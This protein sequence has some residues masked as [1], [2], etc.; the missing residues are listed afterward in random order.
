MVLDGAGIALTV[1]DML[2]PVLGRRADA[3]ELEAAL[4][5]CVAAAVGRA[6]KSQRAVAEE[7]PT[8]IVAAIPQGDVT[9]RLGLL[10]QDDRTRLAVQETLRQILEETD[11][12][13]RSLVDL[14]RLVVDFGTAFGAEVQRAAALPRSALF[15]PYVVSQLA[16]SP[17]A[18]RSVPDEVP[19]AGISNLWDLPLMPDPVLRAEVA[20]VE[21]ELEDHPFVIVSGG[22]GAGKST[23]A[24]ILASDRAREGSTAV[25]W[26]NASTEGSLRASCDALLGDIGLPPAD[27]SPGQVRRMLGKQ[28]DWFLVLDDISSEEMITSV[29]PGNASR[30]SVIAT[31]RD[32][33]LTSLG[34]H[35]RL[36][37]ASVE[38]MTA[39]ARILLP[40]QTPDGEIAELVSAC[41]GHPLAIA[42]T[43]RY[44]ATT[45][46][47]V[48]ELSALLR[49]RPG[50][51][52]AASVG[53][54][55]GA[56]FDEVI[57]RAI[58]EIDDVHAL[59]LMTLVAVAGGLPLPRDFLG[60][61]IPGPELREGITRLNALGLVEFSSSSVRC[62]A[63]VAALAAVSLREALGPVAER[64]LLVI[65]SKLDSADSSDLQQIASITGVVGRYVAR[66][67]RVITLHLRLAQEFSQ[68][69]LSR[70]ATEQVSLVRGILPEDAGDEDIAFV[71][72]IESRV[73]LGAGDPVRAAEAAKRGITAAALAG[74]DDLR[75]ACLV[76][77]VWSHDHLGDRVSALLRAR[78]AEQYAPDKPDVRA[79]RE[80]FEIPDL[81]AEQQ[82]TAYLTLA[83]DPNLGPEG[84]ALYY[85]MATRVATRLGQPEAISYARA[86]LEL[87]R[88]SG[89]TRTQAVAR[90]LN[91]LGMALLDAGELEEAERRLHESIEI[92]VQELPDHPSAVLPRT[93]LG[94]LLVQR[95]WATGEVNPELLREARDILVPAIDVQE[96]IAPRAP[97]FAAVLVALA[98]ALPPEEHAQAIDLL[99][100]ALQIDR[101]LYGDG[102][103]ETGVDALKLM[104]RHLLRDDIGGALRAFDIVKRGT[105]EWERTHPLVAA[106]LIAFRVLALGRTENLSEFMRAELRNDV[107]R[108]RA[109][110]EDPRMS[111]VAVALIGGALATAARALPR[112]APRSV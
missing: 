34:G 26:I 10:R 55:Y 105:V 78:E 68:Y 50:A 7:L 66:P 100:R 30:G 38:T 81:P 111:T 102:D 84:R 47:P 86:A 60:E 74:V 61:I 112:T 93:H 95:A 79:M 92:Y 90:D 49:T 11:L 46:T 48:S 5:D 58:A 3:G 103:Y 59:S 35:V 42:T 91:D 29:V 82:V 54:H 65:E 43:C 99:E 56:S 36:G 8:A 97:E 87:D 40:Q 69:G 24:R 4:R 14:D 80:H 41:S 2:L 22:A 63:L 32:G 39:I 70:T 31:T 98:D 75:A 72:L 6:L 57:D 71:S 53:T 27:D 28:E 13:D 12:V 45:G 33:A 62:H 25:W 110:R 96:R 16:G 20:D 77:L 37:A 89:A 88:E 18:V 17:Q 104:E 94:R 106:Q 73:H 52:L 21:R 44:M 83:R 67:D 64:L 15:A 107:S 108:L 109:L 1:A 51:V 23:I 85:C 101:E 76:V 9:R 19:L